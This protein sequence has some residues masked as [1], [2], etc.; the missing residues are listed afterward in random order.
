[1]VRREFITELVFYL[2]TVLVA[3]VTYTTVEVCTGS[4]AS[5]TAAWPVSI[6]Q[7]LLTYFVF[8][9]I[10]KMAGTILN[11]KRGPQK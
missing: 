2:R 1:M 10:S 4:L 9:L 11:Q 7:Y 8:P 3:R 5:N 6:R